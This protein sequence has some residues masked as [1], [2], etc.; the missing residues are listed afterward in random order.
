MGYLAEYSTYFA[1]SYEQNE[2]PI[3]LDKPY[4]DVLELMRCMFFCP[5]RKPITRKFGKFDFLIYV[6]VVVFNK[7]I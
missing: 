3:Y 6:H 7:K 2:D 5:Q 1:N 4:E